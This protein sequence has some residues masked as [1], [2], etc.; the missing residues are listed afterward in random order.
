MMRAWLDAGARDIRERLTAWA[1]E[2][3]IELN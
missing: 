3:D 2:R 1:V